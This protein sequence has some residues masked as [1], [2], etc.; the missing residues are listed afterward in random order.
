MPDIYPRDHVLAQWAYSELNSPEQG[1]RY[2]GFGIPELRQK[3]ASHVRFNEL[4]PSERELLIK[5]WHKV[6]GVFASALYDVPAFRPTA[7]GSRRRVRDNSSRCRQCAASSGSRSRWS[8]WSGRNPAEG[9]EHGGRRGDLDAVTAGRNID[10][11]GSGRCLI[12]HVH[13]RRAVTR[14]NLERDIA[15]ISPPRQLHGRLASRERG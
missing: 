4:D 13:P 14:K 12:A 11:D 8:G 5:A 6:R 10:R 9:H 3:Q 2:G 15:P 7:R 1:E